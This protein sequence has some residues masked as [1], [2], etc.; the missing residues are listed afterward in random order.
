MAE[1]TSFA[2]DFQD[3]KDEE[4]GVKHQPGK[5]NTNYFWIII[6][7]LGTMIQTKSW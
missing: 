4:V 5:C 7:L 6:I 3:K 2:V 1:K